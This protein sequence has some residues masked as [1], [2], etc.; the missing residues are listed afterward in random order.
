GTFLMSQYTSKAMVENDVNNGSII[1][2]ASIV[3]KMGNIGQANYTASKA[4]V[5][6]LTKTCALELARL[7]N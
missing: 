6:G 5:E 3:G 4:G 1:N 2:I 7:F